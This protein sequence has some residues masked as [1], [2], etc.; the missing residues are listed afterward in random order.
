MS[1]TKLSCP[2]CGTVMRPKSPVAPG[3]KVKCPK[4]ETVFKAPDDDEDEA[5][6]RKKAPAKAP[7]RSKKEEPARKK[8]EEEETYGYVKEEADDEEAKE[9][10]KINY[11]PDESIKDMRGPAIIKLRDDDGPRFAIAAV[12]LVIL[13]A[14]IAFSSRRVEQRTEI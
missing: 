9:R 8:D 7:A 4:C 14:A 1:L 13:I 5:P 3:K 11:A 12:A 6:A 10:K 2:E